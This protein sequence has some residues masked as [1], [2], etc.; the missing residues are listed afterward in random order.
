MRTLDWSKPLSGAS[1]K[2]FA[3]GLAAACLLALPSSASVVNGNF[4]SGL[5]SWTAFGD[6]TA[7]TEATLSDNNETYSYLYQAVGL[8]PGQYHIEF[9]YQ[10]LLSADLTDINAFPDAFFASLYFTNDLPSFDLA[11]SVFDDALALLDVDASGPVALAGVLSPSPTI[12]GWAHYSLDFTNNYSYV[13]PVFELLDFNTVP[14][15]SAMNLDNVS[16]TQP[17]GVVPEPATLTLLA[18]GLAGY[19]ATGKRNAKSL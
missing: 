17:Q 8:A 9:D 11:G 3:L 2:R 10:N 19:L 6:V 15:D 7:V 4:S 13:I 18:M 12:P 1:T 16:I 5:A 14:G